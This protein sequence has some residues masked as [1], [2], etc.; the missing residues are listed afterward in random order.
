MCA[1]NATFTAL[2]V[3]GCLGVTIT[4]LL[5]V[6]G[7]ISILFAIL[8][9][10]IIKVRSASRAAAC[11]ANLQQWGQ[12]FQMYLNANHNK[13]IPS[14]DVYTPGV[15]EWWDHL[16]PY[17][18]DTR[19]TLLCPEAVDRSPVAPQD[20]YFTRG[21]AHSAWEAKHR[22]RHSDEFG[23]YGFNVWLYQWQPGAMDALYKFPVPEPERVPL[24]GDCCGPRTPVTNRDRDPVNLE[25]PGSEGL[26]AY[27]IDRHQFAINLVFVDGHAER[28]RLTDLW[29]L[30]WGAGLH[31][32]PFP[33][34]SH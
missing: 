29:T 27:C 4:E 10:M 32:Y 12:S 17:H 28:V 14:P 7:I 2:P 6:L 30:K 8:F 22:M 21:T 34:P 5:I 33:I 15:M 31:P 25:D 20:E 3:S 26:T 19:A 18:G 11:L 9:P 24:I 1:S 23:S 13:G 16:A